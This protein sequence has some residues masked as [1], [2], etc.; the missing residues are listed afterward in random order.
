MDQNYLTNREQ[1]TVANGVCSN[2]HQVHYGVP[3]GSVLEWKIGSKIAQF[4]GDPDRSFNPAAF[5]KCKDV[6]TGKREKATCDLIVRM[7]IIHFSNCFMRSGSVQPDDGM[8]RTGDSI[9]TID[10]DLASYV[11]CIDK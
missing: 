9:D 4:F 2:K 1:Y 10:P 3:Q 6:V 8:M 11:L 7:S 5:L